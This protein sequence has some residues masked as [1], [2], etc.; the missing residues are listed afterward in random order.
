[1]IVSEESLPESKSKNALEP[2][3]AFVAFPGLAATVASVLRLLL[4]TAS[5]GSRNVDSTL[6]SISVRP[7]LRP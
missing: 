7:D 4:I 6:M 1:M 2:A 5:P 3:A